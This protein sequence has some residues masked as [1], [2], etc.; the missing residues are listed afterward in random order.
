MKFSFRAL[1]AALAFVFVA[2][3]AHAGELA[4]Q[5]G[6][7]RTWVSVKGADWEELQSPLVGVAYDVALSPEGDYGLSFALR[8]TDDNLTI[9]QYGIEYWRLVNDG[10]IE[11]FG[12]G[13]LETW[14]AA[15]TG[16]TEFLGGLRGG[17]RFGVADVPFECSGYYS[18]GDSSNKDAG[19]FF[20]LRA[21]ELIGGD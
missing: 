4:V 5:A 12:G 19:I 9:S 10:I 7:A 11:V 2:S 1:F 15:K 8:T 21:T 20:G 14:S 3:C 17:V 16:T 18:V 6:G 13:Q